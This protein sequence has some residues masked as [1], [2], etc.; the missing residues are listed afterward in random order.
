MVNNLFE[1]NLKAAEFLSKTKPDYFSIVSIDKNSYLIE[2]GGI[3]LNDKEV[4]KA[5]LIAWDLSTGN[6]I[7]RRIQWNGT[8]LS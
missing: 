4:V 5:P 8:H 3:K 7:H 6:Q 2:F 1:R